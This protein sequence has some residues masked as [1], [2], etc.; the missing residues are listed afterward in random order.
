MELKT[1]AQK[2]E[3]K[4]AESSDVELALQEYDAEVG[5]LAIRCVQNSKTANASFSEK[6]LNK[7]RD[8]AQRPYENTMALSAVTGLGGAAAGG[9][10]SGNL[11]AKKDLES[12]A[13]FKRRR[14]DTAILGALA[15]GALGVGVPGVLGAAGA[16]GAEPPSLVE[17]AKEKF[18]PGLA[19]STVAG[20]S[21]G[22]GLRNWWAR[23]SSGAL[24][25]LKDI[26]GPAV[27][28]STP[29]YARLQQ[30]LGGKADPT[31]F[32]PSRLVPGMA[33]N[34]YVEF[35]NKHP[36]IASLMGKRPFIP[37]GRT[38]AP[39]VGGAVGYGLANYLG[40]E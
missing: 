24:K 13:D 40:I 7:I 14:R 38:V 20:A 2:I 29:A 39:L 34:P 9:L 15:G 12:E 31:P 27:A 5:Q 3:Q 22:A 26:S 4:I 21:T 1:L 35:I 36:R 30:A 19:V 28:E 25:D 33:V 6:V 18:K 8:I 32:G 23:S 37:S 11:V 17:R 10:L 16:L